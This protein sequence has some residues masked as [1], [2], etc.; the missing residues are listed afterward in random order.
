MKPWQAPK[1][2]NFK[3]EHQALDVVQADLYILIH[4]GLLEAPPDFKSPKIKI[5]IKR[6][7]NLLVLRQP[8]E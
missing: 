3:E 7:K 8:F 2:D 4:T 6:L 5:K 1:F